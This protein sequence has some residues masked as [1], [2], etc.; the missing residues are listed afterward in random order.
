MAPDHDHGHSH[1][2]LPPR[3]ARGDAAAA[4]RPPATAG[5]DWW[6]AWVDAWTTGLTAPVALTVPALLEALG[7]TQPRHPA[8]RTAG[9]VRPLGRPGAGLGQ[10][11]RP[12]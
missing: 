1:D 3:G 9:T 7:G 4:P 8:P 10:L 12:E 6:G 5:Q 2:P 11:A